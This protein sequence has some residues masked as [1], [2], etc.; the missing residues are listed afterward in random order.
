MKPMI[1]LLML[2][3]FLVP[4]AALS[5]Q[6]EYFLPRPE[7]KAVAFILAGAA[8]GDTYAKQIR[9]WA[10][11]LHRILATE[12]G[13]RPEQIVLLMGRS[14]PNEGEIDGPMRREVLE[15]AVRAVHK[16]L[17]AGDRVFFFL[18]GH[19]TG[20]MEE[21]KFVV[22]GPDITGQDFASMLETF[23]DQDVVIVNTTSA[24]FPFCVA[25][26]VPGRVIVSATRSPA[27]KFDTVFARFFIDAL[28][29]RAGDRDKNRRVSMW[30]AFLFADRQVEKWYADRGRIPTEHAALDD[31]GDGVF[32]V[33]P[34][35]AEEDGRL[36][37]IAYLDP[38]SADRTKMPPGVDV[39]RVNRLTAKI[40]ELE[41]SVF[42][43]R[44]SKAQTP[45]ETYRRQ[46]EALLID[47]A[48]H[49]RKLRRLGILY[50]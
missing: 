28:D 3:C 47:L 24:S 17:Q 42:L 46:M 16:D 9:Q 26:S 15:A 7:G 38:V 18:L 29:S 39:A 2:V 31:N 48:R 49:S 45:P 4:A 19:G 6:R 33:R 23:S 14:D 11:R 40:R 8:T 34:E 10:L 30:E 5:E 22:Y 37:Q 20:N 50:E 12:F 21:A 44:N 36:A 1:R 32:S 25:L 43:L 27:E 41:R 35:P 13:Y